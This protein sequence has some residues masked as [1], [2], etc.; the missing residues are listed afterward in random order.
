[1]AINNLVILDGRLGQD[2]EIKTILNGQQVA[3]LSLATS[4]I[5]TKDNEKI[6]KT[7]WHTII[8]WGKTAENIHKLCKKGDSISVHGKLQYRSWEDQ[9][10]QKRYTTEILC[11]EF[12]LHS[13]AKS[14][15][16]KEQT[17]QKE[18]APS[19]PMNDDI[20]F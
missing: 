18:H 20:P 15:D 5:Y 9:Q 14:Q 4:D 7:E 10:G 6:E 11:N 12:K 13:S 17:E 16:K 2:V 19:R 3:K 8:A 1:M